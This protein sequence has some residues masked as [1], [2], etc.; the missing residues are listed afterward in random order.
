MSGLRT[1]RDGEVLR[2]TLDRPEKRNAL[3]EA[4]WAALRRVVDELRASDALHV[5]VLQA[6]GEVFCAGVDLD[7]IAE[8]RKRPDGLVKLVE[9]NSAVVQAFEQLPQIVV[10]ALNGPAVGIAV[11]LALAADFVLASR[12]AYLQLPE[13]RLGM[14]DVM[15]ARALDQRLGRARALAFTLL[16]DRLTVAQGVAAGLVHREYVDAAALATGVDQLLG[17]L[18]RVAPAVRWQ[19]KR[20][21]L[22]HSAV[23]GLEM[24]VRAVKDL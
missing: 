21:N 8:A 2:I 10:A 17:D 1:E 14:P 19:V 9:R 6:T 24:Q 11:H 3:G 5:A 18:S 7:L 12:D 20:A 4:E 15:H 22:D 13:A 16:G 23:S